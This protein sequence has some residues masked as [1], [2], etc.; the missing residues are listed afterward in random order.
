MGDVPFT[1]NSCGQK[2]GEAVPVGGALNPGDQVQING[3]IDLSSCI[4]GNSNARVF[5]INLDQQSPILY[6]YV[7]TVVAEGPH[8]AFSGWLNLYFTDRTGDRY[9]LGVWKSE[10][11]Q[12]TVAY[13]SED[14]AIV[15]IE[16]DS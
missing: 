8:G 11:L 6:N 5:T 4:V 13:N 10:K 1:N 3:S 16:W 14:P 12:H 7:I 9:A 15:K 2:K